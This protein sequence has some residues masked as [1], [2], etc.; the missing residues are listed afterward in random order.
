M[1]TINTSDLKKFILEASRAT[2]ASGDESLKQKQP[3]GST[4]IRYTNGI[5]TYHDNYFGGEPYGGREV[6]FLN[7]KPIWMMTY[8]G[9][10]HTGVEN[11]GV[12]D[13]LIQSLSHSTIEMPYRG[14]V[15]YEQKGWR[16]ENDFIGEAQ[17]FSGAEKIFKDGICV[18]EAKYIG[19][20]IDQ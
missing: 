10:V 9:F 12:Y 16:Y 14:P 4:T 1:N 5:Y 19:G 2:Y 18:Y 7:E 8:Y 17:N 20:L 3:D 15:S 13:F 11:K 6:V